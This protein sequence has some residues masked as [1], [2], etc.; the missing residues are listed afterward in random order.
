MRGMNG[1]MGFG[2]HASGESRCAALLTSGG[3]AGFQEQ[4]SKQRTAS[5]STRRTDRS[6]QCEAGLH[7]TPVR[8]FCLAFR[9][10]WDRDGL[11]ATFFA[12]TSLLTLLAGKAH[13]I[14]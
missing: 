6:A 8:S 14:M 5:V 2:F 9:F 3:V 7:T 10:V 11:S 13:G 4:L 1:Q 12:A